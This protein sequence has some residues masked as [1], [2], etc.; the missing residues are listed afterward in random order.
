MTNQGVQKPPGY[1]LGKPETLPS[2][3]CFGAH[4][5]C[6]FLILPYYLTVYKSWLITGFSE[7]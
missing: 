5:G 3:N 7:G 2:E 4:W 6:T 1:G